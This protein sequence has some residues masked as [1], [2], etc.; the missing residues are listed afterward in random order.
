MENWE[1]I[2]LQFTR[3]LRQLRQS[4]GL[5]A[6]TQVGSRTVYR[7]DSAGISSNL[8]RIESLLRYISEHYL[9]TEEEENDYVMVVYELEQIEAIIGHKVTVLS[10]EEEKEL[11]E[12][13]ADAKNF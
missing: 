12:L 7:V 4:A 8:A 13:E 9:A 5:D 3:T 1:K 2:L 11:R 6:V 10:E